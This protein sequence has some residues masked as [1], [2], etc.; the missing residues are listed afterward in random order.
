MR[1][2]VFL[3]A[4]VGLA[5]VLVAGGLALLPA[6][7]WLYYYEERPLRDIADQLGVTPSRICQPPLGAPWLW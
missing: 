7:L 5:A 1:N 6:V 3:V 4:A 2:R